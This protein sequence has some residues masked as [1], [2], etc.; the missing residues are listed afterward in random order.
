MGLPCADDPAALLG[1]PGDLL[2]RGDSCLSRLGCAFLLVGDL[3]RSLLLGGESLFL[4]GE[5]LL[6]GGESLLLIS[7]ESELC[8][9]ESGDLSLRGGD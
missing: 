6:L 4:G 1:E 5:S 7:L 3:D 2:R 8:L 9:R